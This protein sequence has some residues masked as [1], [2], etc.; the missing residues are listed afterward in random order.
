[1]HYSLNF[2]KLSCRICLLFC[3]LLGNACTEKDAFVPIME[4]IDQM[5]VASIW[6]ES[7]A[8]GGQKVLRLQ[9]RPITGKQGLKPPRYL[10][11]ED[12]PMSDDG[13]GND[14]VAGDFIYT[15]LESKA[16][17]TAAPPMEM[18]YLKDKNAKTDISLPKLVIECTD[19]CLVFNGETC[20]GK[21]CSKGSIFG[22][23]AWVCIGGCGCTSKITF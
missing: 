12:I 1:M 22:G 19:F 15:S 14:L 10:L 9:L 3:G 2:K 8:D 20:C 6:K 18:L 11:F 16:A 7:T 23:R 5:T 13:T 21:T 17:P 4:D